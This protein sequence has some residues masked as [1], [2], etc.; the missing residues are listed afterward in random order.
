MF[1]YLSFFNLK[2]VKYKNPSKSN[3]KLYLILQLFFT[4]NHL[5]NFSHTIVFF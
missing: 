3:V 2:Y 1:L 4:F 5:E